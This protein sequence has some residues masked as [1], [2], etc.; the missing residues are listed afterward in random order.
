MDDIRKLIEKRLRDKVRKPLPDDP[1][2]PPP[3][4]VQE[5][6]SSEL[7][8]PIIGSGSVTASSI[9]DLIEQRNRERHGIGSRQTGSQTR[10][11]GPVEHLGSGMLDNIRNR[12][13]KKF[14]ATRKKRSNPSELLRS[15]H[16]LKLHELT[17]S[18][19][20]AY[21]NILKEIGAYQDIVKK[22]PSFDFSHYEVDKG[23]CDRRIMEIAPDYLDNHIVIVTPHQKNMDIIRNNYS[24]LDPLLEA[25]MNGAAKETI[26]RI[27]P[28]EPLYGELKSGLVNLIE[29]LNFGANHIVD[30]DFFSVTLSLDTPKKAIKKMVEIQKDVSK[31]LDQDNDGVLQ[32]L[33]YDLEDKIASASA[34]LNAT[35]VNITPFILGDAS[36]FIVQ[37]IFPLQLET[38]SYKFSTDEIDIYSFKT[39]KYV[40]IY[41]DKGEDTVDN[42]N[43]D[44]RNFVVI[45]GNDPDNL[46]AYL[47][48]LK[49]IDYNFNQFFVEEKMQHIEARDFE[50]YKRTQISGLADEIDKLGQ[51]KDHHSELYHQL[52]KVHDDIAKDNI[53][54]ETDYLKT[55][56][57]QVKM[58]LMFPR[59]DDPLV[60]E[61]L[62]NVN[63][64][65]MLMTYSWDTSKFKLQFAAA[66][67]KQQKEMLQEVLEGI[68]YEDQYNLA[69]NE[70]LHDNYKPLCDELKVKFKGGEQ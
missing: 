11:T 18:K 29:Q 4:E 58:Q 32:L 60:Y 70:W 10:Q 42:K 56:P 46:L 55:L 30:E 22:E 47:R 36:E 21:T 5:S 64:N 38:S 48:D 14:D 61:I 52:K 12:K 37:D 49:F 27:A 25:I 20:E 35:Y 44:I 50:R 54:N 15:S 41:F 34:E 39:N 67:P 66:K 33:N 24:F 13:K 45:N 53:G 17:G 2:S 6:E 43:I 57:L 59:V 31:I 26:A 19:A 69:V 8:S 9:R 7:Y 51:D 28:H 65:E 16:T 68:K 62:S 1:T 40:F 23:G 3:E 63:K